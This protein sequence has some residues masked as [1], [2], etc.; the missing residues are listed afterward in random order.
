MKEIKFDE[1][2]ITLNDD[3][4]Q[5]VNMLRA[6]YSARNRKRL[7]WNEFFDTLLHL[8]K[9][10]EDI[11]SIKNKI[12]EKKKNL[13]WDDFFTILLKREK[14]KNSIKS[15]LYTIFI[16]IAITV[17]LMFPI[18]FG[19]PIQALT[20][21]PVFL[22]IGFIVA[23][24]SAYILTPF[25]LRKLKPLNNEELIKIVNE[26]SQ[27]A[28]IKR[29][30]RLMIE[31]TP[32]INAMAYVSLFGN[33]VCITKGL[34]NA[35]KNKKIEEEEMKAILGHEIGHI[36]NLDCFRMGFVLSWIEI[37]NA[38][39]NLLVIIGSALTGGG[40]IVGA[41]SKEKEVGLIAIML[42]WISIISG[43]IMRII[44]K[45]ASLIALHHSRIREYEADEMGAILTSP[46]IMSKSLE[47]IE[48]LNDE[49]IAK[50]LASLP[51]AER[52]QVEPK[53]L[54][55]IDRLF[56]THPPTNKRIQILKTVSD[57][58]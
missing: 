10:N 42:G 9:R 20:M 32:E 58:L 48:K 28:G 36:K 4:Y 54:S 47:K 1:T 29:K 8:E 35:Y 44:A 7:T 26:L 3:I 24:F 18:Y 16:F 11:V 55:W 21:I 5:K 53:N 50:E 17:V 19:T 22:A 33:R 39:G 34:L 45:I 49:L 31:D 43:F 2:S 46:S 38:I 12:S 37:F 27:K 57:F 51:Y 6:S 14:L 23:F 15:W 30:T 52:W 40:I 41:A 56:S 25:S 13:T